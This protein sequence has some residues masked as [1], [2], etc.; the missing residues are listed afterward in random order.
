MYLDIVLI[1]SSVI[2]YATL[3]MFANTLRLVTKDMKVHN[4]RLNSLEHK[5]GKAKTRIR[6]L[7]TKER[8]KHD[9]Y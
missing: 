6:R 9:I 7:E 5:V 2:G 4:K 3:F 8:T 1:I